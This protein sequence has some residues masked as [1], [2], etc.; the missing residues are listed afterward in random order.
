MPFR[1]YIENLAGI[2]SNQTYFTYRGTSYDELITELRRRT[3][4]PESVRVEIY[5]KRYGVMKRQ[6]VSSLDTLPADHDELYVFLRVG[7]EQY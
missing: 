5:D 2:I 7:R 3:N 1:I 6:L 4:M